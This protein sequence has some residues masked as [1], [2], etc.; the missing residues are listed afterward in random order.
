M[1]APATTS[2]A[3]R[4]TGRVIAPPVTGQ[5]VVLLGVIAVTWVL[6]WAF[7]PAFLTS[8]SIQPLLVR[9]APTGIMAVG[10]TFIIITGGIDISVAATLMV[11]AVVTAKLLAT[12]GLAFVP[13]LVVALVLGGVL[14][15]VNGVLIAY[16][17][18]PAIIITFGTANLFQFVGLRIFNS[19]TV[20]GIPGTFATFGRGEAGRTFGVPHSFVI[21]VLIVAAAWWYLRHF[22]G[23]RHFFAIGGD[24]HAA[25]LAGVNVRRRTFLAYTVTGVLVGLAACFTLAGG[26]SSLDQNVGRGQELAVIAAVVIGGTSILGGRGSVLGSVLGALLVQT[27]ASGVTQIGWPSQLSNLF[28]GLFIIVAVGADLVRE[29]RRRT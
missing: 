7:T 9:L 18:V 25:E 27:V 3:A 17:R 16:G 19:Q 5:E 13:A 14:G 6:L 26:T 11:C 21:M 2:P 15:A 1:S 8:E 20:N 10:M 28:V 24:A 22:A 4:R 23:G 12:A 29:R